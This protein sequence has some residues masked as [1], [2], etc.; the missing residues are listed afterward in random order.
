MEAALTRVYKRICFTAY[1]EAL[2][3]GAKSHNKVHLLP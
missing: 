3:G 1:K 2:E